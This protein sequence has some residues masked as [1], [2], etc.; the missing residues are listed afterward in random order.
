M[1]AFIVE[2]LTLSLPLNSIFLTTAET[3]S[4]PWALSGLRLPDERKITKTTAN[5]IICL[6][7][8]DL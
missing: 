5:I 4:F 6:C 8:I 2:L 3:A 7:S 1:A